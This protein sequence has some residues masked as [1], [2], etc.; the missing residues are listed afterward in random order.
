MYKP[1]HCCAFNPWAL[2]WPRP[3]ESRVQVSAS[4]KCF[5]VTLAEN[6]FS[7]ILIYYFKRLTAN[8]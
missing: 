1:R 3:G 2:T 5:A 6:E 7:F 8:V 4:L